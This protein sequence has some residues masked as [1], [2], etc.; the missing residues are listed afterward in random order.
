MRVEAY[1]GL[2]ER[3]SNIT[4]ISPIRIEDQHI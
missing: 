1:L 4:Y 2:Y 3:Q